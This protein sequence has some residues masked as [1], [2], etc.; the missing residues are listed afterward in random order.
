MT[1]TSYLELIN[2]FRLLLSVKRGEIQNLKDR[3]ANGYDCLIK[4]EGSVSVM[5]AEL[6]AKKPLL[7]QTSKEVEEQTVIVEKEA[8]SAAIVAERVSADE[9]VASKAAAEANAIKLECQTEL[10]NAIPMKLAAEEALKQIGKKDITE[11]KTVANPHVDVIMVMS[12]VCVLLDVDPVKKMDPASG[13]KI[14]DYWKPAQS[15]MNQPDFL[16]KLLEYPSEDV[17]E[18]HV[19]K[20]APFTGEEKFSK[21]H[22]KNINMV[23]A[24][25]AGWCLAM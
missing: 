9:A 3:Y 20:L 7:I 24:N 19:K 5:R 16:K 15:M 25:L 18:T 23:A 2:T 21:D 22:L 13:K 12:A 14:V 10:D 17:T 11:I 4:T 8:A 6:E 1:P